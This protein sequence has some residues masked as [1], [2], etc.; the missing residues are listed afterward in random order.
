MKTAQKSLCLKCVDRGQKEEK[1]ECWSAFKVN[2]AKRWIKYMEV[3]ACD[4]RRLFPPYQP[5]VQLPHS[6]TDTEIIGLRHKL[7]FSVWSPTWHLSAGQFGG[8]PW[9]G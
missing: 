2:E 6:G 5:D 7:G 4:S 3:L 9:R 1:I 8:S